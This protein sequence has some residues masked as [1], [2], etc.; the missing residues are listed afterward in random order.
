MDYFNLELFFSLV[1]GLLFSLVT[2][3]F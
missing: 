1:H 2:H 3:H